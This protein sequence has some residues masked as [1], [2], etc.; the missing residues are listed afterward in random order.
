MAAERSGQPP[1]RK[2]LLH[3]LMKSGVTALA[4]GVVG[5]FLGA[6]SPIGDWAEERVESIIGTDKVAI[7]GTLHRDGDILADVDV[8]LRHDELGETFNDRTNDAGQYNFSDTR[9]GNLYEMD[10]LQNDQT[11]L[12]GYLIVIPEGVSPYNVDVIDIARVQV[13]QQEQVRS[14]APGE[15][16]NLAFQD[17][18]AVAIQDPEDQIFYAGDG[19][20]GNDESGIGATPAASP[21]S[22]E[23]E[24]MRL[25]YDAEPIE[26]DGGN[27]AWLVSAEIDAGDSTLEPISVTYY[28]D[29][30]FQ[31]S[32]VTRT[33]RP[34]FQV[35]FEADSSF[36]LGA[37]VT[38][39]DGT[40]LEL[41]TYLDLGT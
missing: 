31:P 15:I 26:G 27:P 2:G 35:S 3:D 41:T 32:V 13:I 19:E 14:D 5:L 37:I 30:A 8:I 9:E 36:Q 20:T 33:E 1:E 11:M 16:S 40:M 28:L 6:L 4:G 29:P 17:D 22:A 18:R 34:D 21:V 7:L 25:V 12:R 10:V 24:P 38:F 39:N 23:L